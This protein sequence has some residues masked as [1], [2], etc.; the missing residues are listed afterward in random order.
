MNDEQQIVRPASLGRAL[1]RGFRGAY[2]SLG[3]VIFTTFAAFLCTTA[4]FSGAVLIVRAMKH[5]PGMGAFVL[6]LPAVLV[7]YLCAVGVF[8]YAG[9]AAK[10]EHPV[11]AD[12]LKGIRALLGSALKL[13]A[14]DLGVSIILLG[15][16]VFFLSLFGSRGGTVPAGLAV[17]SGYLALMWFMM[18]MYHL[19]LLIAQVDMES[20]PR[21]MVV[22]KKAFLLMAGN[23]GF[24]V[25]LFVVIIAFAVLCAIPALIGMAILFLGFAAFILTSALQ[26]L[27]IKYGVVEDEPDIIEEKPW[28]LPE[29]WR[30]RSGVETGES[31][32]IG[33]RSDG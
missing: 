23:P 9:K 22:I 5:A 2:D 29:S 11:L 27:F 21:A 33:G 30:K 15:D 12:T 14:V 26:E 19:P 7:G 1:K 10:H 13:F 28:S 18:C 4:V 24:T 31:D 6:F 8:Y 16:L 32:E 17:L 25:G 20:G 3:Y